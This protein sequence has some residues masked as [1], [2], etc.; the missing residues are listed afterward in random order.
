MVKIYFFTILF[1]LSG[2]PFNLFA[3]ESQIF[4]VGDFDLTGNVKSCLVVTNYGNEEYE[5]DQEG[6]LT[7]SITRFSDSD[8]DITYYMHKEGVLLEKRTENY[9]DGDFVPSTS[10]ANFFTIDQIEPRKVTEK[11]FSYDEQFL[12]AHQYVYDTSGKMTRIIHSGPES[13]DETV[14][15]Y[16]GDDK[17]SVTT[18]M[19][20]GVVRKKVKTSTEEA[21][22]KRTVLTT[23]YLDGS[24]SSAAEEI[25]S[26]TSKLLSEN[27]MTYHADSKK[28][29]TEEKKNY[30]YDERGMLVKLTTQKEKIEEVQEYIYQYDSGDS[31]NWVKQIITPDNLYT[32]RRIKY[33]P[34]EKLAEKE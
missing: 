32:T 13:E 30:E 6:R 25:F 3:Q 8:Y 28:V 12:D 2:L 29:I 15:S 14:I 16:K 27:L 23:Q 22:G 21:S 34:Q 7:K 18:F 9:R 10:F 31:G 19:M 33:Y 11:I 4:E 1:F 24:P 20:N 5:F 26:K 17:N